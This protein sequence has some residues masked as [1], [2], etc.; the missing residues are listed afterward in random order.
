LAGHLPAENHC[1]IRKHFGFKPIKNVVVRQGNELMAHFVSDQGRRMA[2]MQ[3]G[4][5]QLF[6]ACHTGYRH[7]QTSRD[8]K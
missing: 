4:A 2:T 6:L 3:P 5:L 8:E 1:V 7:C